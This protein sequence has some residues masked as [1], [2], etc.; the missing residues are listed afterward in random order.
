MVLLT[1]ALR[2]P[3]LDNNDV[4]DPQPY[5]DLFV[6]GTITRAHFIEST[7]VLNKFY[8]QFYTNTVNGFIRSSEF[9]PPT[10]CFYQFGV[11]LRL[12]PE[13][14]DLWTYLQRD[15]QVDDNTE[16]IITEMYRRY[17]YFIGP[18]GGNAPPDPPFAHDDSEPDPVNTDE[19]CVIQ[20][21]DNTT[22]DVINLKISITP[23]GGGQNPDFIT[24]FN[25]AETFQNKLAKHSFPP[26]VTVRQ[27][28]AFVYY[29]MNAT[30][31]LAE[32]LVITS[33]Q[34]VTFQ[35]QI[36]FI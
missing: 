16:S 32:K 31:P 14:L 33:D 21:F 10:H 22:W 29:D 34:L 4:D 17:N 28:I 26:G 11:Q 6:S 20:T 7:L 25:L 30:D 36:H 27:R 3:N 2:D 24:N 8:Q 15:N 18:G 19:N 12:D 13:D 35:T 9:V 1:S 23:I 5:P